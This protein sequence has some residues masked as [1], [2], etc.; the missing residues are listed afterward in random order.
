MAN[1]NGHAKPEAPLR[2]LRIFTNLLGLWNYE[3]AT[4]V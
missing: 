3:Y 4:T 1:Q 2:F